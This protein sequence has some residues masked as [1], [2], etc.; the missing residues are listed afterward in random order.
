VRLD[1]EPAVLSRLLPR[2]TNR[3]PPKDVLDGDSLDG[4]VDEPT[5]AALWGRRRGRERELY[6]ESAALVSRLRWP[7]VLDIAG[8]SGEALARVV[9]SAHQALLGTDVPDRL[10]PGPLQVF[11][12]ARD[13]VRVAGYSGFDPLDL[14]RILVDALPCFDGRPTAAV[15]R[16][17]RAKRRVN[18]QPALVR[19][20][21]DFGVLIPAGPPPR[22]RA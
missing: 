22:N 8:G 15:L 3:Q 18:L 1:V 4:R 9:S 11:G 13:H 19:R 10:V 12:G 16:E 14:P 7:D 17:I 2:G 20:L 6:R 5:Y 21:V